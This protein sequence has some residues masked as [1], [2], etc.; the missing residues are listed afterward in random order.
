MTVATY[1][2]RIYTVEAIR[3]NDDNVDE[4]IAWTEGRAYR[5]GRRILLRNGS[6][7]GL[8]TIGDWLVKISPDQPILNMSDAKF[9]AIYEPLPKEE[10]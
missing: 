5:D 3:L 6:G 1:A 10:V 7:L 4:V 9:N 2:S 8:L